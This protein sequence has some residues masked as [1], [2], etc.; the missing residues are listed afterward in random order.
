M[1]YQIRQKQLPRFTFPTDTKKEETN[2]NL[3]IEQ[4]N[5]SPFGH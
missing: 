3:S 1:S 2:S 4:A 5:P